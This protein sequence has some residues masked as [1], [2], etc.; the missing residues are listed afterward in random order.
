[1]QKPKNRIKEAAAFG[2][3]NIW[4]LEHNLEN[5]RLFQVDIK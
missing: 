4:W 2:D 5:G 3:W 1:M